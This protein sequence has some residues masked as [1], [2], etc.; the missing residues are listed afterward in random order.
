MNTDKNTLE[1]HFDNMKLKGQLEAQTSR[2]MEGSIKILELEENN[3]K[4]SKLVLRLLGSIE[5]DREYLHAK[6]AED[7]S[8]VLKILEK[9]CD[10]SEYNQIGEFIATSIQHHYNSYHYEGPNL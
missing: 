9:H 2:A 1:V 5:A 4:L 7:A 3:K 6:D 10:R 8:E